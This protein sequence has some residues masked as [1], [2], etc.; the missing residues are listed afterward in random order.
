[1]PMYTN[2]QPFSEEYSQ[3]F[4]SNTDS[5]MF[6]HFCAMALQVTATDAARLLNTARVLAKLK[7]LLEYV[8]YVAENAPTWLLVLATC[9]N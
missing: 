4:L 3:Q 9:A 8:F 5:D 1:M 2:K 7:V 6:G